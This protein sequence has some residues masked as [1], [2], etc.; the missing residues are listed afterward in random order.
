M[1]ENLSFAKDK[2]RILLLEGIHSSAL[3]W[4]HRMGYANVESLNEAL[5]E[6]A[7]IEKMRGVHMVGIRSRTQLTR[8]ILEQADKLMAVG[9]FCIGT[10]QVDLEETAKMG[11]PVFNAPHSNTRS[12][13]EMVLGLVI[14]LYRDLFKKSVAA[15]RGEWLK[16]AKDCHEV[17]GKTLGIVGYGHIGSQVSIL[18]EALGMR[19]LYYDIQAKLPLGNAQACPNLEFLLQNS[20]VVT[21]HVP[22]TPE[23]H[24]MMDE[25][26]LAQMKVGSFLINAS[27]GTVVDIDALAAHLHSGHI[28]GA[29]IDVFPKEPAHNEEAFLSPLRGMEQVILSPHIGGSTVEAQANIGTEVAQKLV[30]YSDRGTTDGAV[31]FPQLQLSEHANAHRILHIHANVPGVLQAINKIMADLEINI[32][33]QHLQTNRSIGYVVLD[34]EKQTTDETLERLRQVNGT[35]RCRI[36]Y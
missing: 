17:R 29:A 20:D 3:D 11:V 30:A 23:T 6:Q 16:S 10:N 35:I 2:I 5:D 7:L 33:G 21:L 31:N 34:I 9:C 1:A 27:R 26:R 32:V 12:V 15:H 36:L 13:A 25:Q 24:R 22:Q 14:V 18:A 4:F 8:A 28:R 19:V